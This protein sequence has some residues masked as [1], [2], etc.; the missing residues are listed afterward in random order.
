MQSTP[1]NFDYQSTTPC[2]NEVVEVMRPYWDE[3]WGNPS[4]RQNLLG[5]HASAAIGLARDK[6]SN[7]LNVQPKHVVF[8]SGATEANNLA[9]LGYA[10]AKA[11]EKGEPGHIITLSTEHHAV[12][13]PLR[14]LRREGFQVT[15]LGPNPDG[16]LSLERLND[17]FQHNTFLASIM[18]ANNEIGVIQPLSL[19]AQLCRDRGVLLHSDAAQA[20]G[21]VPLNPHTLGLD[22]MSI[23]A[24][25]MY[26]PKG[27]GALIIKDH[28]PLQPLQWGGGQEFGLR[29]GTIPVPLAVGMAKA[30]E[31]ACQDQE[32]RNLYLKNLR[33]QFWCGLT[34]NLENISLNGSFNHRLPHNLN[35]TIHG[36]QGNRLHRELKSLIS[37]S[38]GSACSQGS[39]SHVLLALGLN[40]KEASASLRLSLGRF[41]TSKEVATAIEHISR[42]VNKLRE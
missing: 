7:C 10:R 37:C 38:S 14:Q 4:S 36:V 41:T 19:I 29:P 31:L 23:S 16:L 32:I 33:D 40:L 18:L 6:I 30:A 15:E 20:F 24:H 27:I 34:N 3:S 21:C 12:L 26:G 13:D 25:K 2:L 9:L 17:A 5:I 11:Y 8:T 1:L 28:I 22:L 39:P 42:V 35:I